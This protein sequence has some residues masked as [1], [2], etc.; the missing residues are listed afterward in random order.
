MENYTEQFSKFIQL[1]E[2]EGVLIYSEDDETLIEIVQQNER[3]DLKIRPYQAADYIIKD[4]V[5]FLLNG[6]KQ[7]PL[8]VF[9]KHNLMNI[10]GAMKVCNAIGIDDNIFYEAIAG[11]KGTSNR[12]ELITKNDQYVLYKD[13]AH[14]PSKVKATIEAVK[15]QYPD[16]ELIACL[17]LHTFSS[18]NK[19]FLVQYHGSFSAA[20]MGCVY[21]NPHTVEM[22][23]LESISKYDIKKAFRKEGLQVFT[24][25]LE[26]I[27]WLRSFSSNKKVLLMMSSGNFNGIDLKQVL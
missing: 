5:T 13:F 10:N 23:K 25:S 19:S 12:L 1:I 4:G 18:L 20:D 7:I 3:T 17:E 6:D 11:F 8:K 9:G 15:E 24:D 27:A 14:A 22:K 21:Y 26:M 16:H 2:H